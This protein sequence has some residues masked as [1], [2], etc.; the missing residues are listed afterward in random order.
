MTEGRVPF[1]PYPTGWYRI[2]RTKD[3]SRGRV[4]NVSALG[5]SLVLFRTGDGTAVAIEAHCP[6][7]GAHLGRGRVVGDAIE[8]QFHGWRI[9]A[10]G[11]C[12]A[13]PRGQ[14]V[15]ARK[16]PRRWPV[17][18]R[19]GAI[20]LW[21]DALGRQ[22]TWEVPELAEAHNPR[23]GGLRA[24][25]GGVAS[26]HIQEVA[27]NGVDLAH[28][29]HVHGRQ[30][31]AV[32]TKRFE[33]DGPRLTHEIDKSLSLFRRFSSS[34]TL[35]FEYHGLG[36]IVCRSLTHSPRVEFLTVLY[37]LP[38]DAT[39]VAIN[40]DVAIRR[41]G[42]LTQPL[43]WLATRE[44]ARAIADDAAILAEKA[45]HIRPLLNDADGPIMP[46]RKWAS[47]FYPP[48]LDAEERGAW[49]APAYANTGN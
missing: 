39:R 6:H 5:E 4:R 28:F 42:I 43:G 9:G 32:A 1:T 11:R 2:A 44:T 38:L 22:P 30:I 19:N 17:C 27:E 41:R 16:P 7:L 29:A 14:L 13:V 40:A 47:Q 45:H 21:F 48:Q 15:Q 20:M 46:F 31:A 34:G 36:M 3:L 24:A 8:C 26:T 12:A 10:D 25:S 49:A 18:E 33:I 37:P 35:A 23:W